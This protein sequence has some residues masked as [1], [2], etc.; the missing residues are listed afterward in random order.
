MNGSSNDDA[1]S[2]NQTFLTSSLDNSSESQPTETSPASALGPSQ[3]LSSLNTT[4]AED[5]TPDLTI[6]EQP[7][8]SDLLATVDA[9]IDVAVDDVSASSTVPPVVEAPESDLRHTTSTLAPEQPDTN[10][11]LDLD[12]DIDSAQLPTPKPEKDTNSAEDS[13][14]TSEQPAAGQNSPDGVE[15]L[16]IGSGLEGTNTAQKEQ[17][18]SP[19]ATMGFTDT[20]MVDADA[21]QPPASAKLAREREDDDEMEPSAKRTK[22]DDAAVSE[23]SA[24]VQNGE[25]SVQTSEVQAS[26][27]PITAHE[28][29]EIIKVVKNVTRSSHGKNFRAPVRTLWPVFADAYAAKI[30]REVDL[31]TMERMLKS[32]DYP[33]INAFKADVQ[34]LYTNALT[35]NGAGHMVTNSALEV[36]NTILA[37]LDSLPAEPVQ[38]PKK[39]KK[40]KTSTPL[41]ES[42]PQSSKARRASRGSQGGPVSA[43]PSAPS[44][45]LDPSTSMPIIRR[46]STKLDGGRPKREIHPPKSKDLVYSARPKSKKFA[47][48]LKFCE[49]V[50]AE[51]QKY[52]YQAFSGPFLHPVDPVALNIPHYYTI[53]KKP[54][55]LSTVADKLKSGVYGNAH[56]FERD[57][58]QI[59]KNCYLFNPN[60]N[61]VNAMGHQF[62]DLFNTEWEKKDQWMNDHSPAAASPGSASDSDDEDDEDDE[63]EAPNSNSDTLSFAK[64]RLLE[65][66]QKL[67]GLMTAPKKNDNHIAMQQALVNV[68]K[69][70]VETQEEALKKKPKKAKFAKPAKKLLPTKK[71]GAGKKS[72]GG[73]QRSKHLGTL[74]KEV[75]SA[76]LMNL[77]EDVSIEV[78]NDIKAEKPGIDAEE[79][80]TLELD[81]DVISV[82][83]LWK[84][85]DLIMKYSPEVEAEVKQQLQ[86]KEA[87]RSMAKPVQKKKNKPMSSA[88]Q[89]RKIEMLQ[90]NLNA[91]ERT[92]SGSHSQEPVMPC[93]S[94]ISSRDFQC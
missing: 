5:Q 44:F 85:Y 82:P 67:I 35:F 10:L 19:D 49:E 32:G 54:M 28:V 52:K 11:D 45:A 23:A 86:A 81:I 37:K 48:E 26:D 20:E 55:D 22:T 25:T 59:F 46:D 14:I 56:D 4:T 66:Q 57:V 16:Q 69:A 41:P 24:S 90:K 88:D 31:Q 1:A 87:P 60:G 64:E 3:P 83:L 94:Q 6:A 51:M 15:Q 58:K 93:K 53:I 61:A 79:D 47:S 34:Q 77:P 13:V 36:R 8:S 38:A 70:S 75:I 78:L 21:V 72:G 62:E 9:A 89:E 65:E 68:V 42:A 71:S 92:S 40:A 2:S 80:G 73:R 74:E 63:D 43:A 30:E 91:Y 12:L 17:A 33:S 18:T 84:I 7:E 50:L 29:R 27:P 39:D 76:G